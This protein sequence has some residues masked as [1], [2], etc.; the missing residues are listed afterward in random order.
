MI[1]ENYEALDNRR[2]PVVKNLS[3]SER[4]LS[5]SLLLLAA[6]SKISAAAT[7]AQIF[8]TN[9]WHSWISTQSFE[10]DL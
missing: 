7:G 2:A 5:I 1:L 10:L 9:L 8:P 4:S 6:F 3:N